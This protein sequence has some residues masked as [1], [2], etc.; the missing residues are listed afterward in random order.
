M[1]MFVF[2]VLICGAIIGICCGSMA[3]A[4]RQPPPEQMTTEEPGPQSDWS[5]TET[6][7]APG[8]A[9]TPAH[10]RMW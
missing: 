7:A 9:I 8:W 10:L 5:I 6:G 2:A 3:V 1:T 4:L